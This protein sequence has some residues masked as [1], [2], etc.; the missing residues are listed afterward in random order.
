MQDKYFTSTGLADKPKGVFKFQ[1]PFYD[2]LIEYC[3]M[4]LREGNLGE[5]QFTWIMVELHS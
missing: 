1:M 3:K 2:L 4:G 5:Y